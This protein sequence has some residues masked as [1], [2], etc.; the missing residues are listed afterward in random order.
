[1]ENRFT[2]KIVVVTGG[3]RGIGKAIVER[4]ASEGARVY[5]FDYIIPSEDEAFITDIT[6]KHLVITVRCDVTNEQSVKEAFDKVINETS[7]IDILV[8]NAG[9]TRDNL[10]LRMS[11]EEWDAVINTNLKGTFLCSKTVAK[12]MMSQRWGRIINISSIVGIIGNAGQSNYSSSKAGIIGFT[13]SLAKELA[14]RN[15]LVNCIAPGFV[16]TTMTEKLTDEQKDLFLKNIPL[17]RGA[18]PSDIASA[19]AF[20]ASEDANYITG[21]VLNVD[22]GLAM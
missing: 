14:S 6:Y 20:F 19:V 2:G 4:F 3:C 18:L 17:K 15:I 10:I 1:M 12:Q 11:T 16:I 5:A 9:I 21:Q 13:K 22:G 8:N 7:R